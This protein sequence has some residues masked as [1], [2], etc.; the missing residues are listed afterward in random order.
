MIR[1]LGVRDVLSVLGLL[2]VLPGVQCGMRGL[3]YKVGAGS[4][5]QST[6]REIPR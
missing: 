1:E 6:V 2:A 4:R 5:C 3:V